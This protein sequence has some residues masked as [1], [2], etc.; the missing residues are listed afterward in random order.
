[1][2]SEMA[3]DIKPIDP[4]GNCLGVAGNAICV[5]VVSGRRACGAAAEFSRSLVTTG[6]SAAGDGLAPRTECR[7]SRKETGGAGETK[8]FTF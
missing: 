4:W 3:V 8:K 7:R 6:N 2:T 5:L 1:M